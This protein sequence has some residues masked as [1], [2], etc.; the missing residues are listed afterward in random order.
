MHGTTMKKKRK[1]Q[2]YQFQSEVLFA[3]TKLISKC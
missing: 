1:N 3:I 2:F